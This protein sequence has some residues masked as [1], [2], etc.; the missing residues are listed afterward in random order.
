MNFQISK[1]SKDDVASIVAMIREFAAFE[2]LSDFCEVTEDSLADAMFSANS[3][4][5]G[6]IAFDDDAPIGYALFYENF[7]TFRGQRGFYL[8]DLYVKTEY[9]GHGFG[10]AFLR[11]LAQIGKSRNFRRID[12]LVLDW[13]EPAIKFYK[14]LGA[15]VDNEERHFKLTD[16]AFEKLSE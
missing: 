5:E 9:R 3:R 15:V 10:E 12:F 11:K 14:K 2:N 1:A 8:E 4:V 13:N 7:A 6:L 16:A